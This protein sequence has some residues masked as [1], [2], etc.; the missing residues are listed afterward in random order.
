MKFQRNNYSCGPY[1]V[2]NALEALG[3]KASITK[4]RK[5]A[6]TTPDGTDSYGVVNALE[7]FKL[8]TN[9]FDLKL[10]QRQLE[11]LL[12]ESLIIACVDGWGHWVVVYGPYEGKYVIIDSNNTKKNKKAGGVYRLSFKQL[13]SHW[14]GPDGKC[15]GIVIK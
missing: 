15:F 8:K 4:I 7:A 12:R 2:Y 5:A 3:I 13:V 14:R 6:H 9:W 11:N 1:A 10:T